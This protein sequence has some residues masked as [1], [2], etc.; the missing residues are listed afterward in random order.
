MTIDSRKVISDQDVQTR[1]AAELPQWRL[2]GGMICRGYGTSGWKSSL[3]V[4]NAIGHLVEVAWHHPDIALSFYRV[5]VRLMSHDVRGITERD[6]QLAHKIEEFVLWRPK[7]EPESAFDGTP[8][9]DT[10]FAYLR[11]D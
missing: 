5:E 8:D 10:R 4:V 11:Y 1:L 7:E 6:L 9:A 2:E 3:L